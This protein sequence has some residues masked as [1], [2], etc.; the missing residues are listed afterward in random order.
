[1]GDFNATSPQ[2]CSSDVYNAA[3]RRLEPVFLRLGLHQTVTFPTHLHPDGSFGS[4]LDL[5]LV[6]SP[7]LLSAVSSL[8]PLGRSDHVTLRYSLNRSPK[9]VSAP[10]RLRRLWSYDEVD[11]EEVNS[12]LSNLDW[13]PVLSA[14]T[15]DAGWNSWKKLFFSVINKKVPSKLVG[16]L[17]PKSPWIT[18]EIRA[19]IK[20]KHKAWRL[21]KRSHCNEHLAAFRTV[22]NDV[23]SALR[24]AERQHLHSLHRDARLTSAPSTVKRF[25]SYVKRITGRVKGSF[26]PDLETVGSDGQAVAVSDDA[27]KANVLNSFFAKQTHL[28]STPS[29]FPNLS[30]VYKDDAVADAL[31]T[32]P[33]EVFD[34]LRHLK[35]GKAPGLDEISPNLLRLCATGIA[36]SLSDL[37]NRSFQDCCVPLAWKEALVVPVFKSGAKSDPTNYRPIALL[38]VVCKVME[39]IVHRRLN[40]FLEPVLT[41]KQSG[42]KKKDG[43]QLQLVRLIQEWSTSMDDSHLVGV[44]FFD[45]RKAFDRVWLP[46]LLHK[47][48]SV[49]VR[50]KAL[51]WFNS[52]LVGRCQRTTVGRHLSSLASLHAGVPQGAVLS[53]LLFSLYIN[54]IVHCTE[55]NVNLFADDTSVYVTDK[56]PKGLQAKLQSVVNRLASWFDSWALTVN[57]QKSALMVLTTRRAVPSLDVSFS[58]QAIRQVTTHKN[59]G[60]TLDCHLS[61]SG[62]VSAI[63][64]KASRKIGLLR[65]LRRRLPPLVVQSIYVTCIRPALEYASVAWCGVGTSDAARLEQTQ[66]A[67]ARLIANVSVAERMPC[68]L[69]IARAGLDSLSQ[70]RRLHCGVF[71]FQLTSAGRQLVPAHLL[72]TLQCW[73]DRVP[74]STS[75]VVLRSTSAGHF[76]LP[77][78][79]TELFRRSPFYRSVSILN[80]VPSTHLSSLSAVKAS[81]MSSDIC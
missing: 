63:V 51:A 22:R 43:T 6:S 55:A 17:R 9:I 21:F 26:V 47:L 10:S 58:T 14:P 29:T 45:I 65:R 73:Q 20:S 72:H 62:H 15:M 44:V 27:A 61:W 3:G 11:F 71:G 37:F 5:L 49:G 12:L 7:G 76:R 57:H 68:A 46:G 69:L 35:P 28:T 81:L 33:A 31:F 74:L 70:R 38:S 4:L 40:A 19:L 18:K 41:A 64:T 24:K 2:W 48:R 25:W 34:T 53:P 60:L 66:R 23:T 39:K 75:A 79:R 16:R 56:S 42:F 59:M 1:M 77:R 30:N 32:T 78:P 13:S 8:P 80:S 50:G 52:Y 54:D 67:A 36:S